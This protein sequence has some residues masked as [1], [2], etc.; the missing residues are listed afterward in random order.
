MDGQRGHTM[1]RSAC[2]FNDLSEKDKKTVSYTT[3]VL[4]GLPFEA[5]AEESAIKQNEIEQY[6]QDVYDQVKEGE[7]QLVALKGGH[8]EKDVLKKI[9][10][11][12]VNIELFG[13]PKLEKLTNLGYK[14]LIPNCAHHRKRCDVRLHCSMVEC[15]AFL[16]WIKDQISSVSQRGA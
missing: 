8:R 7:R 15:I 10:I 5:T 1:V 11:P 6:I 4:I 12:Y 16:D 13:C 9:G 14:L 2:R 3:N